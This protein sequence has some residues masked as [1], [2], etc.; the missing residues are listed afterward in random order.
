MNPKPRL[1]TAVGGPNPIEN[2]PRTEIIFQIKALP[3]EG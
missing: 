2:A 3:V 1:S